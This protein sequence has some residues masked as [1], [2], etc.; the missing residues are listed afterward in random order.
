MTT[1]PSTRRLGKK[2]RTR[3]R[4]CV[5]ER[6]RERRCFPRT[7]HALAP[8][9]RDDNTYP[10]R[11]RRYR[12]SLRALSKRAYETRVGRV[13]WKGKCRRRANRFKRTD[14]VR[15]ATTRRRHYGREMRLVGFV[16]SATDTRK[17]LR[18]LKEKRQ[19]APSRLARRIPYVRVCVCVYIHAR[20]DNIVISILITLRPVARTRT[21]NVR[22]YNNN[23]S[24]RSA[25]VSA[26]VAPPA[27]VH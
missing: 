15:G 21:P 16:R 12:R 24:L 23:H 10:L 26:S 5:E 19:R 1:S 17:R 20:N 6:E 2:S 14:G 3:S 13:R 7:S 25:M 9:F 18:R 8:P 27:E 11:G 22:A 4:R